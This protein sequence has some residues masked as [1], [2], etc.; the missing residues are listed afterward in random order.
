MKTITKILKN[1]LAIVS[2]LCIS[3]ALIR[4]YFVL[5]ADFPLN[6]GGMFYSM[7]ENLID[8]KFIIP[9]Y[10]TYNH[11]GIPYAYSPFTFYIAAGLYSL[12]GIPLI[13]IFRFLPW[14][15]SAISIPLFYI[16]SRNI[17]NQN[18][19]AILSLAVY[20]LSPRSFQAL[21]LGG[22]LTRAAGLLFSL[23]ALIMITRYYKTGI[24]KNLYFAGI[25]FGI[26][27]LSHME[28]AVFT[29]ISSLVFMLSIG[30]NKKFVIPTLSFGII[31]IL[32][33]SPWWAHVIR[34]HGFAPFI[35]ALQSNPHD[36]ITTAQL[37]LIAYTAEPKFNIFFT[38]SLIGALYLFIRKEY[39]LLIWTLMILGTATR[40][41]HTFLFMPLAMM[42]GYSI[43]LLSQQIK[44]KYQ[45]V[46]V[47]MILA[48]IFSFIST[49]GHEFTPFDYLRK[50]ERTAMS[51]INNNTGVESEFIVVSSYPD[52]AWFLDTTSEWFPALAKRKSLATVQAYE[53]LPDFSGRLKLNSKFKRCNDYDLNCLNQLILDTELRYTHIYIS[54]KT[55][56][57]PDLPACCT[58]LINS[59]GRSADFRLIFENEGVLVYERKNTTKAK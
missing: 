14:L 52:W 16:L 55:K 6:D 18:K 7:V 54:K 4:L 46:L 3:G 20:I 25:F 15:L 41:S 23:S 56:L 51:W 30:K 27:L 45:I 57:E 12:L 35:S 2:I 33:A 13:E 50:P 47:S 28:F 8:N 38:F 9:R 10:T 11:S 29:L 53:W 58:L 1:E 40:Q 32:I 39:G 49:F 59:I 37:G 17:L 24:K 21:I 26:C 34:L 22:G 5:I 42:A 43:H 48:L 44:I 31:G 36:A 19:P